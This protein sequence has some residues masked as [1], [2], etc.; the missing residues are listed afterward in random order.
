MA[1]GYCWQFPKGREL[2]IGTGGIG[3]KPSDFTNYL[4]LVNLNP[5][6]V[7]PDTAPIPYGYSPEWSRG[8]EL[9]KQRVFRVGDSAGLVDPITGEGLYYALKSGEIAAKAIMQRNPK[10]YI[11]NM[12]TMY[13]NIENADKL[14]SIIFSS[15]RMTVFAAK[16]KPELFRFVCDEVVSQHKV[17]YGIRSILSAYKNRRTN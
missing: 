9:V 16:I 3:H 8:L 12:R 17:P 14:K 11:A 10:Y 15:R 4:S 6:G 7:T 13:R 5:V 2:V 1:N